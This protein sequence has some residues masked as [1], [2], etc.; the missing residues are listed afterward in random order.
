MKKKV[1]FLGTF[2]LLII[3]LF[4]STA[5][6]MNSFI[7]GNSST[8]SSKLN[9]SD[10]LNPIK[11]TEVTMDVGEELNFET[12]SSRGFMIYVKDSDKEK[13]EFKVED[14]SII[15]YTNYL[16]K[17]IALK[18]GTTKLTISSDKYFVELIVT[19]AKKNFCTDGDFESIPVGTTWKTSNETL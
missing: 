2:F 19:V 5:V 7:E 10:K 13:L 11:V 4:V 1:I 15:Y 6:F 14:E 16:Y 3:S 8:S 9:Q 17:I 18:A 12:D